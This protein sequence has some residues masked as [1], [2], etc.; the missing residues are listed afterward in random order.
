MFEKFIAALGLKQNQTEEITEVINMYDAMLAHAAWKKR[1]F[2]YLE[3]RSREDLQ[4]NNIRVDHLCLLGK[5]IHKEGKAEFGDDPTFIKLV[6]EHA[7]FHQNASKVVE[8]HQVGNTDLALEI[9][10]GSFEEQSR[11]TVNC[12]TRLNALVE[13][14]KKLS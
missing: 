4:P 14:R 5:W 6:E 7:K 8:A 10:K 13:E 2:E 12:L 3:G 9:L 11:K 1:L